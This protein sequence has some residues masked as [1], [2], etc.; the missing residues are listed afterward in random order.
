MGYV[1]GGPSRG[2]MPTLGELI[3]SNQRLVVMG[4]HA[5]GQLPWYHPAFEVLQETP[6]TFHLPEHFSCKAN[7]GQPASPLF[8]MNHWIETTPAPRPSYA[9]LVNTES[10][11][12]K[13]AREC[14]RER[15]K[16]PNVIAVDFAA[17]GDVVRAAAVLNGTERARDQ[18]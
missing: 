8:L 18:K 17:T 15:G 13:R 11:L 7:R 12:L 4:E 14:Q 1:Y 10:V 6:H 2:S 16:L 3:R 5:T 9:K